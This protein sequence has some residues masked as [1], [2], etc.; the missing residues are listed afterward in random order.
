LAA[1]DAIVSKYLSPKDSTTK[2]KKHLIKRPYGVSVTD[3]DVLGEDIINKQKQNSKKMVKKKSTAEREDKVPKRRSTKKNI[4]SPKTT[5]ISN[6]INP[7]Q[8]LCSI[9]SASSQSIHHNLTRSYSLSSFGVQNNPNQTLPSQ[10]ISSNLQNNSNQ[11]LPFQQFSS[12]LQYN[13]N[14]ILASTQSSLDFQNNRYQVLPAQQSSL[15][16]Q[17]NPYETLPSEQ[18]SYVLQELQN[19]S[20]SSSLICGRCSQQF[21]LLNLGG[22]CGQCGTGIC[23]SCWSS[24]NYVFRYCNNCRA[25]NC[26]L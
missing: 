22:C 25:H 24:K 9:N 15:D 3:L 18:S 4:S 10:Q 5:N 14:Q 23:S 2:T 1:I 16:L 13:P 8:P 19:F 17:N 12:N 26:M 20:T 7:S 21:N 11:I 6:I